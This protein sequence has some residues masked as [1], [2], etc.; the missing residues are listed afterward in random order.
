MFRFAIVGTSFISDWF[1][2]SVESVDGAEV[3]CVCSRTEEKGRAFADRHNIC[4]VYTDFDSMLKD[5]KIDCVY[6]ASPNSLH[7]IQSVKCLKNGKHV[8]CEK[9]SMSNSREL[10]DVLKIAGE[11]GRM[12]MEAYKSV[13]IPGMKAIF[14]N[15][16]KV[17]KIRNAFFSYGKYSSRYDA[18][19]AGL[20]VNTFKKEFSNG[21]LMDMGMYCLY[22]AVKLFGRP[23]HIDASCTI[24]ENG[25]VDCE[26]NLLMKYAGFTVA[27]EYSKVANLF[28]P[29][30]IA[31]EEA[32][33]VIDCIYLP[34]RIE[35]IYRDGKKEVIEPESDKKDMVYEI[36][37]F[38]DCIKKDRIES[39]IMSHDYSLDC[40][41]IMDLARKKCGIVYPADMR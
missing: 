16:Y 17:G 23:E 11:N 2:E 20:D 9:P 7:Y 21:A 34:R 8:L 39:P 38:L 27:L 18:H 4:L 24:L 40:M 19:M 13:F 32:T 22:P 1:A 12:F 31:G 29:S 28:L 25:G 6:I 5:E 3:Y 35:L 26:G 37:E 36:E 41:R 14:D 10:V 33:M 30:Q 15:L